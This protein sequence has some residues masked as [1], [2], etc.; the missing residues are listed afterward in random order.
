SIAA[1]TIGT[2]SSMWREKRVRVST[3]RGWTSESRGTSRTSSKVSASGPIFSPQGT[4]AVA[5]RAAAWIFSAHITRSGIGRISSR[6]HPRRGARR[7][8]ASLLGARRQLGRLAPEAAHVEVVVGADPD[9]GDAHVAVVP[10][11]ELLLVLREHVVGGHAGLDAGR[12]QLPHE[13]FHAELSGEPRVQTTVHDEAGRVH[14]GDPVVFDPQAVD[15]GPG[16]QM[17]VPL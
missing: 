15:A 6:P 3:S 1:L 7:G 9:L 4:G 8:T 13:V 10:R 12:G 17:V 14:Q 5:A 16:P 2:L 11:R